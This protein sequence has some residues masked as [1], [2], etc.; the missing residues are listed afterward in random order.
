LADR[1]CSQ[2]PK[3]KVQRKE[4]GLGRAASIAQRLSMFSSLAIAPSDSDV[5]STIRGMHEALRPFLLRR[6]KAEMVH[7]NL[8]PKFNV[9][10]YCPLS[11]EQ[12]EHYMTVRNSPK[13]C[14]NRLM[15]L[16][17]VCGHTH[18]FPEFD[19]TF[20]DVVKHNDG[21]IFW[22]DNPRK[23]QRYF[24][25][26]LSGSAKLRM[27]HRILPAL[28]AKGHR[29]LIFSQMTRMLD[30]IEEYI[31][32]WNLRIHTERSIAN[33]CRGDDEAEKIGTFTY[34][35]LDG[36]STLEERQH[37]IALFKGT[38]ETADGGDGFNPSKGVSHRN[39]S[40]PVATSPNRGLPFLF[41]ISTRSGG[42]GLNIIE[43]DTVILYDG[44]F[45]PHNDLQAVDRC[46]RIGQTKPVAVYRLVSPRTVEEVL[47][48]IGLSKLKMEQLVIG[49][50]KFNQRSRRG[51]PPLPSEAEEVLNRWEKRSPRQ[52]D[53]EDDLLQAITMK[54]AFE[55]TSGYD[56]D[57]DALERLLD[58]E[59]LAE[60]C[61]R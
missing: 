22:E 11:K 7:L 4:D 13:Y 25:S 10:L 28:H 41:L 51:P 6:T 54:I 8:P 29:V 36:S 33:G 46:H 3:R 9:L 48:R 2:E 37:S 24:D 49:C 26:L 47:M 50:G 20:D 31:F 55:D 32:H 57:D 61:E 43:A 27:L 56:L 19:P 23:N 52:S 1:E 14:N 30:I 12:E 40:D 60:L 58:R 53:R 38:V 44:D 18:S 15:Q 17:K 35:R 21:K 16:R 59:H 34:V 45:N 39:A 5:K 42:L